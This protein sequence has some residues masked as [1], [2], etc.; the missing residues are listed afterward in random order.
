MLSK[1]LWKMYSCDDTVRGHSKRVHL[2]DV[3]DSLLDAIDTLPQRKDSR[4]EP[5]FEPHYKLVSIIHKLV[6]RDALT[7]RL[8]VSSP[9]QSCI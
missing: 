2:D 9:Y 1:C 8:F 6:H 7:V 5:I 4:S 3:V